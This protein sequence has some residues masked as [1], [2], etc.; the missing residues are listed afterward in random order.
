MGEDAFRK[1][2][3]AR[4]TQYNKNQKKAKYERSQRKARITR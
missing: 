4:E 1:S 3:R 2:G